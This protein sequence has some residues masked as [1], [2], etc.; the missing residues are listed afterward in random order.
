MISLAISAG[1]WGFSQFGGD[2][3]LPS[4]P[5]VK[6]AAA[7]IKYKLSGTDPTSIL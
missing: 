7:S 1:A 2:A 4:A 5:A 6:M 3:A